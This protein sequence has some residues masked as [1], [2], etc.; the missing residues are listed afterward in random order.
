MCDAAIAPSNGWCRSR[1]HA[2]DGWAAGRLGRDDD[3]QR[4]VTDSC[5]GN[6]GCQTTYSCSFRRSLALEALRV[7]GAGSQVAA[8]ISASILWEQMYAELPLAR[9]TAMAL[10]LIL[11]SIWLLQRQ[12]RVA[13]RVSFCCVCSRCRPR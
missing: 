12:A 4:Q 5:D 3:R 6:T 7:F 1:D 11:G 10:P 13:P 2:P 9:T 8:E